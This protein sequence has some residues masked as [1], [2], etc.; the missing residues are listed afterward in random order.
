MSRSL[1]T[2]ARS[3]L[4]TALPLALVL[5]LIGYLAGRGGG[6]GFADRAFS[7]QHANDAGTITTVTSCPTPKTDLVVNDSQVTTTQTVNVPVPGMSKQFVQGGT[8][9]SCVIVHVSSYSFAPHNE[10][11]YIVV[12]LDGQSSHPAEVQ[13]SGND[14]NVA[15][16]HA[17]VFAFKGVTQG[18]H[19]V[20]LLWRTAFGTTIALNTP[21]MQIQHA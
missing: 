5:V 2:P 3:V 14:V 13:M 15:S 16:E 4:V 7:T 12:E 9:P 11:A 10:V 17:A 20:Q 1:T 19:T 18:K 6:A 8:Y 21:V